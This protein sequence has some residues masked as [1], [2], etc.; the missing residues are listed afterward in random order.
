MYYIV[1]T[2]RPGAHHKVHLVQFKNDGTATGKV[3]QEDTI[4]LDGVLATNKAG[5]LLLLKDIGDHPEKVSSDGDDGKGK[6]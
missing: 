5:Q 1:G 6:K 2:I 3:L 4:T